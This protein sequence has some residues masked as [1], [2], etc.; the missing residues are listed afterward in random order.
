M[1]EEAGAEFSD[2]TL[3]SVFR[4]IGVRQGWWHSHAPLVVAVS[5]GA[6]SVALLALLRQF[7]GG[8]PVVAH[9]EHGIRGAESEKDAD[10]VC[11]LAARWGCDIELRRLCVP[12]LLN[13]GESMEMGARRIRYEFLEETALRRRASG[14][15]LAHQRGDVVETV[16]MNLF[17]GT[18]ARG[19]AGIPETRK[20]AVRF[21]R[22]LLAFCHADLVRLLRMRGI[23]WRED[24]TN[25]DPAYLRNRLRNVLIP[26]IV[27]EINPR[28][29]AHVAALAA[30]MTDSRDAEDLA[31][32]CIEERIAL[33]VVPDSAYAIALRLSQL[34]VPV[35]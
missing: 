14:A 28:A 3:F 18:G 16:L 4:E 15:A 20:G 32:K 35:R 9:L 5:G 23:P 10:F 34:G 24:R 25:N 26:E 19:L 33:L 8:S 22:P 17:R 12:E 2:A 30:E 1:R 27:R 7:W 6:D 21:F 13:R 11:E 31:A 29:E